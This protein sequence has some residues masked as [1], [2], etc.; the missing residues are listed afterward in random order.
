MD[1][2]LSQLKPNRKFEGYDQ[3]KMNSSNN[4]SRVNNSQRDD[5]IE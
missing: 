2:Q 5:Q 1:S 3:P 4:H